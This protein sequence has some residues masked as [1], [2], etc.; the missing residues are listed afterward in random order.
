MTATKAAVA[1]VPMASSRAS[2]RRYSLVFAPTA[3]MAPYTAVSAKWSK[4]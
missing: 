1:T 2:E 3:Q 4:R